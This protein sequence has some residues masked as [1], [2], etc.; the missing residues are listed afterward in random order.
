MFFVGRQIAIDW[1]IP[2][3][4]YASA[5]NKA[6]DTQKSEPTS[7]KDE[8]KKMDDEEGDDDETEEKE[9][10]DDDDGEEGEEEDSEAD[11]SDEGSDD[12]ESTN[13]DKKDW[14]GDNTEVERK[15]DVG[16]G[17]TL[18][19]R[20]LDF[21]TTRDSLKHYMEQ[22]GSVNYALLCMDKVMERPKGTGFVKFN[23]SRIVFCLFFLL[24]FINNICVHVNELLTLDANCVLGCRISQKVLRGIPCFV[25]AT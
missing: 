11:D 20:N 9:D 7:Q 10:D 19:I 6:E 4:Q 13:K 3:Q 14:K 8:D 25:S 12:E 16:E 23:A 5:H 1:A 22:F 21:A 2:K 18:F 24:F 15:S 17:K